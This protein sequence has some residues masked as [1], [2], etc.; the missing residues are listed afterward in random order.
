MN[1]PFS[2]SRG[3]EHMNSLF[4]ESREEATSSIDKATP[5]SHLE[6][7]LNCLELVLK[8]FPLFFVAGCKITRLVDDAKGVKRR[9][10]HL[11]EFLSWIN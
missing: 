5:A 4:S 11:G 7:F 8:S 2:E 3:Q 1:S 6:V 10:C 9:R